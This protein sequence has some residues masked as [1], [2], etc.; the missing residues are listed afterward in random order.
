ME[1]R[2]TDKVRKTVLA[3]ENLVSEAESLAER[4]NVL[5]AEEKAA[6]PKFKGLWKEKEIRKYLDQLEEALKKPRVYRSRKILE[7]VGIT[8]EYI[9]SDVLESTEDIRKLGLKLQE[10]NDIPNLLTI[11]EDTKSISHWLNDD[12]ETTADKVDGIVEAREAFRRL[13]E[14][15]NI[16]D[17]LK[18]VLT[19]EAFEDPSSIQHAEELDLRIAS[20]I[21]Y[22]IDCQTTEENLSLRHVL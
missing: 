17:K 9:S 13:M 14:L 5:S 22:G 12:M 10:L 4:S 16:D 21:D 3:A 6:L 8:S 20:L 11:L 15:S 1:E 7:E 19:L 18:N 2:F